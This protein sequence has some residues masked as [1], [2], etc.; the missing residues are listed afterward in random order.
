MLKGKILVTVGD[1]ITYGADMDPAGIAP[2]GSLMTYG[3][4]I[5]ERNHKTAASIE[6]SMRTAV[7]IAWDRGNPDILNDLFG[8]TILST[9]GKPTNSEFIAMIADKIRLDMK[10]S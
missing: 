1:S 4:Q 8:Y 5:A 3:W 9:R 10:V 6:R 2:D 7:K